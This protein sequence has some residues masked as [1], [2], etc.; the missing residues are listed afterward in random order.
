M[1]HQKKE[2]V[3]MNKIYLFV[4]ISLEKATRYTGKVFE[5]YTLHCYDG[6]R[7]LSNP[8]KTGFMEI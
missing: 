4:A 5:A 2:D 7:S 8:Y 1:L 6:A 3:K